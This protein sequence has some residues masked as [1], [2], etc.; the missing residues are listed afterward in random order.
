MTTYTKESCSSVTANDERFGY[1]IFVDDI[2]IL[3]DSEV[4]YIDGTNVM[5]DEQ[6]GFDIFADNTDIDADSVAYYCDGADATWGELGS[7]VTMSKETS[8]SVTMTKETS[9]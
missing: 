6:F 7:S 2:A 1:G 4:Y 8:S 3:V 5:R 9:S